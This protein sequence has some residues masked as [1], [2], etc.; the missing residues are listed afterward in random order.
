MEK[1]AKAVLRWL[2][3]IGIDF[4]RRLRNRRLRQSPRQCINPGF[5][6]V[7]FCSTGLPQLSQFQPIDRRTNIPQPQLRGLAGHIPVWTKTAHVSL[8]VAIHEFHFPSNVGAN[9]ENATSQ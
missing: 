2:P 3:D 4:P 1:P 6:L 7:P 5:W 9:S 8:W